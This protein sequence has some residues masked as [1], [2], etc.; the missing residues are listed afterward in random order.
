MEYK[1]AV[2]IQ[3]LALRFIV[4]DLHHVIIVYK[5]KYRQEST[6]SSPHRSPHHLLLSILNLLTAFMQKNCCLVPKDI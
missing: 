6:F 5:F 2:Q 4:F 3:N 1:L